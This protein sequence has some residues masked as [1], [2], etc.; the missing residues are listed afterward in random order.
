MCFSKNLSMMSFLFGIFSSVML[1]TF[2]NKQYYNTNLAIGIFY[3]FVSLMQLIEYCMWCD[4]KCKSGLNRLASLFGP[5]LNTFQPVIIVIILY[6]FIK[7]SNI[8]P[9][10]IIYIL[11]IIYSMYIFYM[12]YIYLNKNILCTGLNK[13]NHLDWSWKYAFNYIFYF[14]ILFVNFANFIQNKYILIAFIFTILSFV[15]F[16]FKFY[17]N[18]GEFWCLFV[19][20][21]PLIILAIQK[22][23][24]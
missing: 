9:I 4:I 2:G 6:I 7:P 1:I 22:V 23:I 5:L 10:N 20:G 17:K 13:D 21:I 16:Y 15:F 3:I 18:M 24:N 19:T 14:I 8:I 11:N 12:Y